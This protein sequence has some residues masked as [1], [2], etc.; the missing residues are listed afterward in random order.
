MDID[1][2]TEFVTLY[3]TLSFQET[4]DRLNISQSSLTKH[5][6]KLEEE[7]GVSLFDRSTRTVRSNAFSETFYPYA[8]QIVQMEE[9]AKSSLN[10]LKEHDDNNL[11]IAFASTTSQ[12]GIVEIISTFS[13]MY[14]QYNTYITESMTAADLLKQK[15]CDFAFCTDSTPVDD[16]FSKIIYELDHLALFVPTKHPLAIHDSVD[17]SALS[18]LRL[19]AHSRANG[20]YHADT[21]RLLGACRAAGIEPDIGASVS[22]TST[23]L[24]FVKEGHGVGVLFREQIPEDQMDPALKAIDLLP[25]I[26]QSVF[27]IYDKSSRRTAARSAFINYVKNLTYMDE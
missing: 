26:E 15:Q 9:Q 1:Q 14:P 13:K 22:Y 4:S 18:G 27:M 19:I 25:A 24:K 7:L 12:Y 8:A 23:L 20:A 21:L 6:H 11:R 2:L 16:R 17:I 10:G 3:E 5:I